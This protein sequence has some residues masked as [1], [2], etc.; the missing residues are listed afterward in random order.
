[1]NFYGFRKVRSDT[2]RIRDASSPSEESRFHHDN[3]RRDRPDLLGE[4]KKST[5]QESADKQEVE[6]LKNEVA[7]LKEQVASATD[8]I[9]RLMNL[10][11]NLQ[12]QTQPGTFEPQMK[13]QRA[14]NQSKRGHKRAVSCTDYPSEVYSANPF[15]PISLASS[16]GVQ[17]A[18]F[19]S[20]PL[21]NDGHV[22]HRSAIEPL[23]STEEELL[24]SLF[25]TNDSNDVNLLLPEIPETSVAA[26]PH[27]ME[28]S[29]SVDPAVM[30]KFRS[31]LSKLPKTIQDVMVER[32]VAVVSEP[33]AFQLQVDAVAALAVQAAND[34][35]V[36]L[37]GTGIEPQDPQSV[38]LAA[39]IFSGYLEDLK[40]KT[41]SIGV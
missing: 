33:G 4:I 22:A 31:A 15:E 37:A 13:K 32:M 14:A 10:V 35:S 17:A 20:I 8:D 3:F 40:T 28:L 27:P 19:G 38:Q 11:G 39:S 41:A 6:K 25:D 18:T 2:L 26:H 9:Q 36:R 1:L 5:Q 7:E 29:P 24:T 30:D 21:N 23:T 12:L 16:V 34:A